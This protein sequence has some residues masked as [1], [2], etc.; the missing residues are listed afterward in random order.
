MRR[1]IFSI[2]QGAPARH[3]AAA[4]DF[5][6]C[7][8]YNGRRARKGRLAVNQNKKTLIILI[9]TCGVL[10]IGGGA[11][12]VYGF[13]TGLSGFKS[14]GFFSLVAFAGVFFAGL[15]PHVVRMK[16]AA[17]RLPEGI[18]KVRRTLQKELK[19]LKKPYHEIEDYGDLG[20]VSFVNEKLKFSAKGKF[21]CIKD[22]N[23]IRGY[24]LAFYIEGTEL[25]YMPEGYDD[26]IDYQ[27]TLFKIELGD[28]EEMMLPEDEEKNGIVVKDVS[29]L[30]GKTIKLSQN[31]GYPLYL[32]T[33]ETD[34]IDCGEITFEEWGEGKHVIRLKAICVYGAHDI[35]V[36]RLALQP[37]SE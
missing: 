14:V 36:G 10:A 32:E 4:F 19:E 31:R 18:V 17:G 28:S 27:N 34:Y 22:L 20:F 24:H 15:V 6:P 5:C 37:D 25:V 1:K 11:L 29:S 23:G 26:V 35:L 16:R 12:L 30:K 7:G 8:V 9:V 3:E 2:R 33:V 13:L 21:T